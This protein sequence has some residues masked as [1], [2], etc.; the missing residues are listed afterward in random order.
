MAGLDAKLRALREIF[1]LYDRFA[2]EIQTACGKHCA[3]CCTCNVTLT[4]LEGYRIVEQLIRGGQERLLNRIRDLSGGRRFQPK[5]TTNRL[6]ELCFEGRKIPEEKIDPKWGMCAFLEDALCAVY[7]FR[8][9]GCRCML[10]RIHCG[11]AGAAD[12]GAFTV[13]VN[14]LF[15]QVIEHV[16]AG[17]YSGNLADIISFLAVEEHRKDYENEV[18]SVSNGALMRNR[19]LRK[20]FLPPEHRERIQPILRSLQAIRV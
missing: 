2:Q 5:M 10:S 13:S 8:P 20:L 15:L 17:G 18:P 14:T 3:S 7:P 9:F 11:T 1:G 4:T 16:D 12:I 6:A 19:P